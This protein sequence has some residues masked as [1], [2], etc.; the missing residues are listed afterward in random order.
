MGF[1]SPEIIAQIMAVRTLLISRQNLDFMIE[2]CNLRSPEEACGLLVGVFSDDAAKSTDIMPVRNESMSP[3]RF[4]INP[5]VM[6]KA[7]KKAEEQNQTIIGVYHSHP[8]GIEPSHLDVNYMEGTSY[9]WVIIERCGEIR[10]Y[11]YEGEVKEVE[12]KKME[13]SAVALTSRGSV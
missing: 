3:Y 1:F 12:I 2:D 9:V 8:R 10:A 4:S 6:F 13:E 7:L 5:V 11:V